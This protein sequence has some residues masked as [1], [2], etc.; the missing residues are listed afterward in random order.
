MPDTKLRDPAG[1]TVGNV[2]SI[3]DLLGMHVV[4]VS[5]TDIDAHGLAEPTVVGPF[6]TK[7]EAWEYALTVTRWLVLIVPLSSIEMADKDGVRS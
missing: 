2:T 5:D 7:Q 1:R 4:I 6:Q 3:G